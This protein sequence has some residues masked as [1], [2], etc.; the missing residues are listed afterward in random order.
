MRP[1]ISR[2]SNAARRTSCTASRSAASARRSNGRTSR[3]VGLAAERFQLT[4]WDATILRKL[5]TLEGIYVK[6]LDLAANRRMKGLER[7]VI[8]PIAFEIVLSLT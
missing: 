8:I 1:A 4:D 6:F 3:G 2:A 7:I 5:E